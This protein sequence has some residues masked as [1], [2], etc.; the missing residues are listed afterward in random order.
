[1]LNTLPAAPTLGTMSISDRSRPLEL[2]EVPPGPAAIEALWS[3]LDAALDH[4]AAI[5]P[6]PRVS[7]SLPAPLVRAVRDAVRPEEPVPHDTAIVI[8]TSGST[9]HPRGVMIGAHALT[10][11]TAQVHSRVDGEP[12]WVLALPPT[13]I[14]GLNVMV[15][16]HDTGIRPIAVRS[17]GGAQPFTDDAFATAVRE[18]TATGRPIAVSLVPSQ[19]TRLLA[20]AQGQETLRQ[21]SLTLVGGGPVDPQLMSRCRDAGITLTTTYG[22]TETSGGCVFDGC[23]LD[24][25]EVRIDDA[26]S[27]VCIS[28][29]ML[30]QG[31]RDGDDRAFDGHWLRTNDRGSWIDGRV[32]IDGRLDD[33]VSIHGVNVDLA[34]VQE[35]V[36]QHPGIEASL[37]ALTISESGDPDTTDGPRIAMVY[38]GEPVDH[39]ELRAWISPTLGAIACPAVLRR[40]DTLTRTLTGKVDRHATAASAGLRIRTP[41][42][43][44]AA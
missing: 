28:G 36:D 22:M 26:D 9:G 3:P 15:R 41:G 30:A 6:V 33:I 13:S 2:V 40:V 29:P 25:V 38:V 27:R 44:G 14:G 8:S 19:V 21:C 16:A 37:I 17:I 18:A 43:E 32:S 23:P 35:R 1:M 10:A 39:E 42:K 4:D 5:A 11:A 34:A 7:A 20:S 12:I 24:G 31:Y